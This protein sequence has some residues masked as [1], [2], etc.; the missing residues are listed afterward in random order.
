MTSGNETADALND[1]FERVKNTFM[2]TVSHNLRSPIAAAQ[3]C[4]RVLASGAVTDPEDVS[5]LLN[6]AL[7]RG[8]DALALVDDML[9]LLEVRTETLPPPAEM[10]LVKAVRGASD[11]FAAA[12][13][14]RQVEILVEAPPEPVVV[15][16][17]GKMFVMMIR[18][19][20]DNAVKYSDPGNKVMIGIAKTGGGVEIKT[21]SRGLLIG[22]PDFD[23]IF[24]EFW[25]APNAK[26][27]S[28]HGTGL[29]L[30]IVKTA[31]ECFGGS[32]SLLSDS[33]N[34]TSFTVS[35]PST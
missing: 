9:A 1:K 4:L 26:Q 12:A 35:I 29:G 22:G 7:E 6:N 33:E 30:P 24:I 28:P 34:G 16:L 23:N 11:Y 13:R 17:R 10:D 19:L 3:S 31:V 21:T 14:N 18:N 20:I 15:C 8:E 2:R 25:R 27:Y 5:K 32:I